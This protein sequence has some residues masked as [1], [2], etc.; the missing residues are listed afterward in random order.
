MKK[1]IL[2]VGL[3][4]KP[5]LI[6]AQQAVVI[7]SDPQALL[8]SQQEQVLQTVNHTSTIAKWVESIQALNTQIGKMQEYIQVANTVKG[9]IGDPASAIDQVN[10]Q[11][12]GQDNL[13]AGVGQLTA[14]INQTVSGSEALAQSGQGLFTPIEFK[15]PSGLDIERVVDRY[16]P[17]GAI[18]QQGANVTSVIADTLSRIKQLQQDKADTLILIKNATSETAAQ[19]LQAKMEAIDGEMAALGVQQQTATNQLVAQDIANRNDHE[20]KAQAAAEA[21][22][23]ELSVS[24]DN[25]MRW[26]GEVKSSRK[27]FN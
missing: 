14:A 3:L 26:Q 23:K 20:M 9:Y 7:A 18:Q 27:P 1:L 5:F 13:G 8:I 2:I 21:A 24:V 4:L 19:K 16:K 6:H 25:F 11:L 15:T 12:L 22:D 10:I 17:F